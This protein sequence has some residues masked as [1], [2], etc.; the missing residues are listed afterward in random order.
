MPIN[1]FNSVCALI[2]RRDQQ[3]QSASIAWLLGI[4][5]DLD[6]VNT[7]AQRSNGYSVYVQGPIALDF[8]EPTICTK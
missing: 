3:V 4:R 7:G 2:A 8:E 1:M 5:A 6:K